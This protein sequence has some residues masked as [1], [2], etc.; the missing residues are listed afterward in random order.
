MN[1]DQSGGGPERD[2]ETHRILTG[3]SGHHESTC[4]CLWSGT[5]EHCLPL[6]PLRELQEDMERGMPLGLGEGM[7]C[8]SHTRSQERLGT[9]VPRWGGKGRD[10]G[11]KQGLARDS[12][13]CPLPAFV[14]PTAKKWFSIFKWLEKIKELFRDT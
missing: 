1:N 4:W 9:A 14:R 3:G 5:V 13:I 11:F 8:A 10:G 6:G 2:R 7:C 12:H